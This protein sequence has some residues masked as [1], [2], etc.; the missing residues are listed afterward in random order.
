MENVR[1][2]A[3]ESSR[4]AV[5]AATIALMLMV[6]AACS[7][8]GQP[9]K[10]SSSGASSTSPSRST[11]TG[12][13]VNS[14]GLPLT[15]PQG[16]SIS[17]FARGVT[18]ARVMAFDPA[19]TMLLSMPSQGLV[20]ALPDRN[21]DGVADEVVQVASGLNLPHGL[22]FRQVG[23]AWKLYI[24]ETNAVSA[25]DYDPKLM[26]T[27]NR[28]KIISL[29]GGGEHFTRTLTFL[30]PPDGRLLIAI[31]SDCNVC[32]ETDP[33]RAK[34]L[35]ANPDGSN[36][37]TFASGLRNSVFQ[38]IDP[39]NGQVWSTEMG[40]DYLGDNLPPDEINIITE[41]SDYGWPTLYGKNVVDTQ[42]D[43]NPGPDPT[44]GKTPSHI[45]IQAHS[46]PLG[47]AFFPATGWPAGF[48]YNLLVSYHGSWNR[49]VP[50]GYKVVR[51]NLDRNGNLLGVQDFITGWLQPDGTVLGRPVG[52]MIKGGNIFISDDKAGVVYR[53][54]PAGS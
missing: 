28:Q 8:C 4:L 9:T 6:A 42:F 14:T 2:G 37:K 17:Y 39:V 40:R 27:A 46:A 10:T 15:L 22:A 23:K 12:A 49:S 34:I 29:S 19:G 54:Y 41:G 5:H 20:V 24:A 52:V 33:L 47:L 3:R 18:D 31:G 32:N 1:P 51:Y 43:P 13:P 16:F 53:V 50:T 21:N 26:K 11:A 36:L 25:Y 30:P 44:A 48:A 45:D 7:S 38:T 35:V